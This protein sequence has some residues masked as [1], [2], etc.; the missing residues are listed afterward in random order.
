VKYEFLASSGLGLYLLLHNLGLVNRELLEPRHGW[1]ELPHP[2][3]K[4]MTV[5]VGRAVAYPSE[6]V[7]GDVNAA[8]VEIW[9]IFPVKLLLEGL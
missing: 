1:S 7:A 4:V 6:E 2:L 8:V 5:E 3:R 9:A